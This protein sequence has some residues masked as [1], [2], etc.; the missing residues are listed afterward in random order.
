MSTNTANAADPNPTKVTKV[1]HAPAGV[2]QYVL[3]YAPL[4]HLYSKELYNPAN[5]ASQLENTRP[6]ISYKDVAVASTPL[7]LDNMDQLNKLG[8]HGGLDVFLTSK[9]D[10]TTNPKWLN[11][12]IPDASGK[13][14]GVTSCAIIVNDHGSGNVDVYYM[15][16]YAFNWG[17]VVL[18]DQLGDHVGDWEHNMI[19]YKNGVPQYVWFSQHGNGEAFQYRVLKKDKD[20]KRVSHSAFITTLLPPL[21]PNRFFLNPPHS[22]APPLPPSPQLA[23]PDH[24]LQPIVY[25]A[26]GSHGNYATPGI[27]DHTFPN[28]NLS[29]PFL[30]TDK[31]DAGPLWDPTLAAYY[32]LYDAVKDTYTPYDPATP[33]AWLHYKGRWGDAQYPDSDKRQKQLAGNRK[34]VGGPTGPWDK[35]LNRKNVCP[36]NG[37]PCILR[38][39]LGP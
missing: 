33:S 39:D 2:P 13:T 15:Y 14:N 31:T 16:F 19:R 35:Q 30:L 38:D 22:P 27:H 37:L 11:G 10:I 28:L 34:F 26:N 21:S 17:G 18:G 6:Q 36:D 20:G 3:D 32:Y 24:S 23:R 25:S 7:T 5:I 8:T 29:V 12:V 4:V 1:S 9:V